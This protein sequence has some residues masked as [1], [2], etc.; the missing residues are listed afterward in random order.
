MTRSRANSSSGVIGD[1]DFVILQ[2]SP[3]SNLH[4]QPISISVQGNTESISEQN[5]RCNSPLHS[6]GMRKVLFLIWLWSIMIF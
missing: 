4:W 2:S 3:I 6:P 1:T 5:S